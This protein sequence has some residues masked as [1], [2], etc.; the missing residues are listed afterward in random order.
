MPDKKAPTHTAY[1]LKRESRTVFRWL[2]IGN[3]CIDTV[4]QSTQHLHLDRL[5]IGGFSGH[6]ILI[7]VGVKP[8]EPVPQRPDDASEGDVG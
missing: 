5:P 3:A 6:V 1:A 7:P 2:E 8:P 4:G